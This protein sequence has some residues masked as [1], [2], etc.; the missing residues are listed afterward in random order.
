MS[1][2][3]S[4]LVPSLIVVILAIYVFFTSGCNMQVIDTTWKFD[5][6]YIYL[7]GEII[8]EGQ[9]QSWKDFENSDMIQVQIDR[10]MYLTNSSNVVLVSK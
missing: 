9:V 2:L 8:K 6:G 3:K 1:K 5:Y 4:I 10:K 7:D